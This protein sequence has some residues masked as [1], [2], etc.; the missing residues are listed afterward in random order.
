MK[1][2][3]NVCDFCG[4]TTLAVCQCITCD[5]WICASHGYNNLKVIVV[6][7]SEDPS[8]YHY[9][10]CPNC[11]NAQLRLTSTDIHKA[12]LEAISAK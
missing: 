4:H 6:L 12:V 10:T 2:A 8:D 5:K 9:K 11:K 1:K 7:G 3:V